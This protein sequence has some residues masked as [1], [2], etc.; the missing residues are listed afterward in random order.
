MLFI[1]RLKEFENRS[2]PIVANVHESL[3]IFFLVS[4]KKSFGMA[5]LG[6]KTYAISY[7]NRDLGSRQS[8]A[9]HSH[10]K[11]DKSSAG[12]VAGVGGLYVGRDNFI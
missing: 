11:L 3:D 8:A 7:P 10:I 4:D 2:F 1:I 5:Q 9:S 12:Q 6:T